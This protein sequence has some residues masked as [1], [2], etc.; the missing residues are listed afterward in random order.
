MS[1]DSD[2]ITDYEEIISSKPKIVKT[3]TKEQL[4]LIGENKLI[5]SKLGEKKNMTVKEIHSLFWD[6]ETKK[7]TK[8]LKTIYRYLELLEQ[9]DLI[10]VSGRRKYKGSRAW[11]RL[12]CRT[13]IIYYPE[14]KDKE[15]SYWEADSGKKQ[16]NMITDIFWEY[17]GLSGKNKD[18]FKE[19]FISFDNLHYKIMWEILTG[20]EENENYAAILSKAELDEIKFVVKSSAM[21]STI[22]QKSDII[23]KIREFLDD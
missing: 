13:S 5:F 8:T 6:P 10:M 19:L 20:T 9:S 11:E 17:H 15:V 3:I 7:N 18:K 2:K 23:D 4:D 12:Y 21:I 1:K 16:L 14:D 22:L